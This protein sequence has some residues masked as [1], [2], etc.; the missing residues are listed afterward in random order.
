MTRS[1]TSD[2]VD[3]A[4]LGATGGEHGPSGAA[5]L[6]VGAKIAKVQTDTYTITNKVVPVGCVAP[7]NNL[8]LTDP[9]DSLDSLNANFNP[10]GLPTPTPG[11]QLQ[12]VGST[13]AGVSP[14]VGTMYHYVSTYEAASGSLLVT[15]RMDFLY[16]GKTYSVT[17][18][19]I[20]TPD[21]I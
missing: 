15:Y 16:R 19:T 13:T 18:S 21:Q 12:V 11:T 2:D 9:K 14:I 1:T 7:A 3:P 8:A 4:D 10:P 5:R 20:R 17:Q 6:L